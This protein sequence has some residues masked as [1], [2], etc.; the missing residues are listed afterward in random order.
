MQDG[1]YTGMISFELCEGINGLSAYEA[2]KKLLNTLS[3]PSIAVS[4]GDPDTLIEHPASMT[5]ANVPTED[6]LSAG[7]TDG[8]IRLSVG[9]ED[10][11]D[12]IEDFQSAFLGL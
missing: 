8:L 4:L 10:V 5:H 3:I 6:R 1:M 2:G 7:I 9:L 12:L 11:Q